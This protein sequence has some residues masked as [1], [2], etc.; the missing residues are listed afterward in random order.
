MKREVEDSLRTFLVELVV[1][2]VLVIGYYFLVLH[3][4]G[5]WLNGL[6]AHH[7]REYAVV[8]LVFIVGQG[9]VLEVLTRILLAW[10]K[11]RAEQ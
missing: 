8:A 6:F 5:G 11:P 9:L 3:L 1:Y 10:I 7:R 4:L 2:A